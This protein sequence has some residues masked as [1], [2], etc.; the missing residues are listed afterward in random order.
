MNESKWLGRIL[1][2]GIACLS[3]TFLLS[4]HSQSAIES[5]EP[6]KEI[7]KVSA[8]VPATDDFFN[9]DSPVLFINKEHHLPA[10]YTPPDLVEPAIPFS[11]E[12]TSPKKLMRKEAAKATEE[13]FAHAQKDGIALVGVSAY[14]SFDIQETIYHS[15]VR[16]LGQEEAAKWS[17]RPGESEHQTG[18]A[19]DISTAEMGF[20]LEESFA[21]TKE[22]KWLAEHAALHGFIIRYPKG[23][24][25]LTGYSYEPW[26]IRYVGKKAAKEISEKGITL[27]EYVKEL[28]VKK[29]TPKQ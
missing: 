16:A 28:T 17:A 7:P 18:L 14:R 5:P 8:A 12:G 10:D 21:E 23:K 22:G 13:L 24:E 2:S 6:P 25:E 29:G 19:I 26:H 3:L 1:M 15:N 27:E 20:L 9:L 11:F 4:A